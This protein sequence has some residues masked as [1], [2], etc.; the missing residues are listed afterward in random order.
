MILPKDGAW[1]RLAAQILETRP[2]P[3]VSPRPALRS[4]SSL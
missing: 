3:T 4:I 1:F 2:A